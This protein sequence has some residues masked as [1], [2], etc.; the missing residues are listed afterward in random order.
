MQPAYRLPTDLQSVILRWESR[1][2][3]GVDTGESALLVHAN[4]RYTARP[5]PGANVRRAGQLDSTAL[6][7]LLAE[8]LV[9]HRFAT[10]SSAAIVAQIEDISQRTGRLFKMMDGG[11][12][13][14]EVSLP[15]VQHR[16]VLGALQAAHRL[17]P[18]VEPL[19]RLHAVQQRLLALAN[20]A[21][22]PA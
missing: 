13:T 1:G 14:I 16:V 15:D 10:I 12:T 2:G 7:G 3:L 17:F 8:V 4:G 18:E 21:R 9:Q 6:Q 11:E 22:P 5:L 19:Q 20:T